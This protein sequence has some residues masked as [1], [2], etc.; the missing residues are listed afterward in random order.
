MLL[1]F[2][3]GATES[4][5][6]EI[7]PLCPEHEAIMRQIAD[8]KDRQAEAHAAQ[9]AM[10]PPEVNLTIQQGYKDRIAKLNAPPPPP[11]KP[12]PQAFTLSGAAPVAQVPGESVQL[13][14]PAPGIDPT[15]RFECPNCKKM[16]TN[17]EIH[18]CHY[19]P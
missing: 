11:P 2:Y 12:I 13:I 19:V 16:V 9:A 7:Q 4:A 17:G 8:F 6:A 15:F 10:T 5:K 18:D 3:L 14:P 1:G